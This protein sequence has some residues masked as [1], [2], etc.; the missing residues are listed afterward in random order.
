ME[1][2]ARGYIISANIKQQGRLVAVTPRP[3]RRGDSERVETTA[4]PPTGPHTKVSLSHGGEW[5]S[6]GLYIHSR[7]RILNIQVLCGFLLHSLWLSAFIWCSLTVWHTS[8]DPGFMTSQ[9]DKEKS[10]R[11]T[12]G[13][14]GMAVLFCW[15]RDFQGS[16]SLPKGGKYRFCFLTN[17]PFTQR[18]WNKCPCPISYH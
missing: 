11:K 17:Q 1:S 7:V 4:G 18:A 15:C 5:D 9:P 13:W 2:S 8:T 3:H 10:Q 12:M 16:P 14:D 6:C